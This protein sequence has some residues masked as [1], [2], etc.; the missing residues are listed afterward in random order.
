MNERVVRRDLEG[1]AHG[2]PETDPAG[3]AE[4]NVLA[5]YD[6]MDT[7]KTAVDA[8][9]IAGI[10]SS[11][12]RL[13]GDTAEE[14]ATQA[15]PEAIRRSD[16]RL[17]QDVT[18]RTVLWMVLGAAAGAILGITLSAIP[19]MPLGAWWWFVG[20]V[21][22]GGT[23]GAIGGG[24]WSLNADDRLADMV[25]REAPGRVVVGVHADD[26][27]VVDRAEEVLE[28]KHPIGIARMDQRGRAVPQH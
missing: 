8:L 21:I 12:I 9:Q 18:R 2:R 11:A 5:T 14:A 10:D 6:G 23:A 20:G 28:R 4:F 17:A 7:A 25:Y 3:L 1:A 27:K 19:E 16:E 13:L 24:F 22:I 26:R 15:E